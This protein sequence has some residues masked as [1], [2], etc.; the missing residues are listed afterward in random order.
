MNYP[1]LIQNHPEKYMDGDITAKGLSVAAG[2][3]KTAV[4]I[5]L[6]TITAEIIIAIIFFLFIKNPPVIFLSIP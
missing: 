4:G 1:Y 6:N 3:A 5:K 2:M